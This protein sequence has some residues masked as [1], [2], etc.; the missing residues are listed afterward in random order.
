MKANSSFW[1]DELKQFQR[2]GRQRIRKEPNNPLLRIAAK[3]DCLEPET[4]Y[5]N[6]CGIVEARGK[7]WLTFPYPT[8]CQVYGRVNDSKIIWAYKGSKP[9]KTFFGIRQ[10]K[11]CS[12]LFIAKSPRECMLLD[13]MMGG[14]VDVIGLCTE[15]K[16]SLT[17]AQKQALMDLVSENNYSEIFLF[18]SCDNDTSK[19]NALRFSGF[20]YSAVNEV[21]FS[22]SVKLVDISG[23][24]DKSIR[25]ITDLV[26]TGEP[27]DDIGCILNAAITVDSTKAE[28][29]QY[30]SKIGLLNSWLEDKR[31][32]DVR[33]VISILK[34]LDPIDYERVRSRV[35]RKLDVR[36]SVL[37]KE[38]KSEETDLSNAPQ[39][40]DMPEP[41]PETVEGKYLYSELVDIFRKH[42]IFPH[43]SAVACALWVMHTYVHEAFQ[44]SPILGITSPEKRCG[45]TTLLSLLEAVVY[46]P[47]VGASFTAAAIY[48]VIEKHRPTL[49]IDEADT[50]LNDNMDL[51]GVIN[52]G[53]TKRMAFVCRCTGDNH[54]PTMFSTW[55]PKALACIGELPGTISDRSIEVI[56]H[57]KTSSDK[58]ER[59]RQ[60]NVSELSSLRSKLIRW[61]QDNIDTLEVTEPDIPE[62]L[63]DRLADTWEPLLAIA[64]VTGEDCYKEAR[65][66]TLKLSVKDEANTKGTE[67]LSDIQNILKKQKYSDS[68]FTKD[69]TV[70]LN[71]LEERP[72]SEFNNGK[73]LSSRNLAKLLK[74]FGIK[75]KDIR[76]GTDVKKGYEANSFTDAF[77]RY[78]RVEKATSATLLL[79]NDLPDSSPATTTE[80]VAGKD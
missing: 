33:T 39:G 12:T 21:Q 41:W 57:R 5:K 17:S 52:S 8:G 51:R 43:H 73:G 79:D 13:Q 65:E 44:I 11:G 76:S 64:K 59:F 45:K 78:L 66:A 28:E 32:L 22:G 16:G 61:G 7:E 40:F 34:E 4:L 67:L 15:V 55:A 10:T 38:T 42:I 53:H 14:S 50:F 1:T 6:G 54:E 68:I 26:R 9:S 27:I 71:D 69:L 25:D 35:S 56:M 77:N 30:E 75:S 20:V 62:S 70:E 47:A 60:K 46:K 19:K 36:V 80:A 63:S 2:K 48:R 72:W 74:P 24:I 3:Y 23:I 49:I 31:D 18:L 29:I 58:V 37:D